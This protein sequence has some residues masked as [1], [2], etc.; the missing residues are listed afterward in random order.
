MSTNRTLVFI[1]QPHDLRIRRG[2]LNDKVVVFYSSSIDF[3]NKVE[4]YTKHEDERLKIVN[5]A[6]NIAINYHDWKH[7][8]ITMKNILHNCPV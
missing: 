7:R 3:I 2:I 8:A 6:Y 4:Y 5:E 1:N